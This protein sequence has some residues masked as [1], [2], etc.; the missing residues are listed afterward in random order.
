[1]ISHSVVNISFKISWYNPHGSSDSLEL[2]GIQ[3]QIDMLMRMESS[4]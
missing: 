3:I 4:K 1:M 2:Q